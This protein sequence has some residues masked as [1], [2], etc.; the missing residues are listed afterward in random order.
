MTIKK[1]KEKT[2]DPDKFIDTEPVLNEDD[3]E[4][5]EALDLQQR[6]A[7]GR[8]LR[9]NKAKIAMGRRR[10]ARKKANTETL[11]G[12]AKKAAR[13]VVKD[14]LSGS[15]SLSDMTPAEKIALDKRMA[16]VPKHKINALSKKLL[17]SIRKKENERV[18]NRRKSKNESFDLIFGTYLQES[19]GEQGTAALL[20]T[21]VDATPGMSVTKRYHNAMSKDGSVLIDKRFKIYKQS[22]TPAQLEDMTESAMKD[23]AFKE[24][25]LEFKKVTIMDAAMKA[26]ELLVSKNNNRDTIEGLAFEVVKAF[27]VPGLRPRELAKVYR[28]TH[29]E[30]LEEEV[31]IEEKITK[32]HIKA[33]EG[34][35]DKLFAKYDMDIEFTRHFA[36]RLNDSRNSPDITVKELTTTLK[37]LYMKVRESEGKTLTK[38]KDAE[39]VLKD[40]QN[41]LNMP[42]AVEYD[43][44][45]D[46]L[47]II[48]KTVMRKKNFKT[49]NDV[50]KV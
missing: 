15:K 9:K 13:N 46:E 35:L 47:D 25:L 50:I 14:K 48:M 23:G 28:Q 45:N 4:V 42:I 49:P 16:K 37:K 17:P 5:D 27:A 21:Y 1:K 3:V 19:A 6:R 31:L 32:A 20:K 8:S 24:T 40:L 38:Y 43:R 36:D 34:V 39:A 30:G 18:A 10:A 44:K 2:H 11:K 12:R 7:R 33:I 41:D 22:L 29:P 26:L